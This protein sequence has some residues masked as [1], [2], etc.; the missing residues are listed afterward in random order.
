MSRKK[1]LENLLFFLLDIVK[2]KDFC[3]EAEGK[4]IKVKLK[5]LLKPLLLLNKKL[6]K[7]F[8]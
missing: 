8:I 6:N 1:K 4:I 2:K 3:F 7:N 5:M